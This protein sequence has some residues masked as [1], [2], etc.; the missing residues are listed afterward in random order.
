MKKLEYLQPEFLFCEIPIKDNS[1]ND[2]R[3]WIYHRKSISL[4]EFIDSSKIS[5][6]SFT[7]KLNYFTYEDQEDWIGI[8]VQ[9]NCEITGNVEEKILLGAWNFLK[10]YF[11]WED[12]Q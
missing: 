2:Q 12:S 5:D 11:E 4:I 1:F 6:F 8:F 7:G 3:I 9:N 10:A